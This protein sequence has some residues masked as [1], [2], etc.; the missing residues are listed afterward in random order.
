MT[1]LKFVYWFA[2]YNTDSPSVRYRGKYAL[3]QLATEF[4]IPSWFIIPGY[5]PVKIF[6]FL[7][8]YFSALF[9]RKPG[10]LIVIQR[11]NSN[12]IYANMLKLLVL[13]RTNKTI[14]DT[15]DADYL[16]FPPATIN[17]FISKC[18]FVM[19]GSH[20]LERNLS[21]KNKNIYINTSP[22]PDIGIVKKMRSKIFTIGWIGGFGGGHERSLTESLFPALKNLAF[23]VRLILAGVPVKKR[24][25]LKL[26][27]SNFEN[28]ELIMPE[29]INWNDE[30]MLQKMISTFDL[31]IA[32][33]LDT[34]DQRSKSAFKLKQYMCNG[35][36]VLSSDIAENN[37]FLKDGKNGFLCR[38]ISDF[39][40]RIREFYA[41]EDREYNS[42]SEEALE[43]VKEFNLSAYCIN[44]IHIYRGEENF[45]ENRVLVEHS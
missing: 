16:E 32:T 37:Y 31:G 1:E 44:L 28:I 12:F 36:P 33:L 11:V 18:N 40:L 35:V 24:A 26:H 43:S 23:P 27:F 41:M 30:V 42:F 45:K 22:V 13:V 29:N 2:Y 15:D 8:A 17:Y 21:V 25:E 38:N 7:R 39:Y 19:T 5:S 34:I 9:F 10:S 4:N 20:E 14:Y 3:Q 6:K